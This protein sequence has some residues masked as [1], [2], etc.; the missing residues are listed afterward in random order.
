MAEIIDVEH[1]LVDTFIKLIIA[2]VV[3]GESDCNY[4]CTWRK[5]WYVH[6]V[7]R[8]P[9]WAML[10]TYLQHAHSLG[11]IWFQKQKATNQNAFTIDDGLSNSRWFLTS[12]KGITQHLYC[13]PK[14]KVLHGLP[15][16]D[17]LPKANCIYGLVTP[18]WKTLAVTLRVAEPF[19]FGG[20]GWM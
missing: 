2:T 16:L 13:L 18:K 17:E 6:V 14:W 12:K 9:A 1:V 19:H 11:K 5:G 15:N 3:T 10:G 8:Y 20:H 4:R 7:S